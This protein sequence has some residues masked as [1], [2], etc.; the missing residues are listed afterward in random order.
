METKRNL[1]SRA[2]EI[3]HPVKCYLCKQGDLSEFESLEPPSLKCFKAYNRLVTHHWEAE[4]SVSQM[5]G[6]VSKPVEYLTPQT[7]VS[8][9]EVK[10]PEVDL[11][12]PVYKH[13]HCWHSF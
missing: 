6:L 7:K 3:D 12:T 5:C 10:I 13:T 9:T 1:N 2:W 8:S 4:T 11:H